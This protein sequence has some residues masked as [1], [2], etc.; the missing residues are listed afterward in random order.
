MDDAELENVTQDT[1]IGEAEKE[2]NLFFCDSCKK[3]L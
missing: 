2:D 3:Q 1:L